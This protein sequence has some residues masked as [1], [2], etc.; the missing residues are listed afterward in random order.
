MANSI[1]LRFEDFTILEGVRGVVAGR[2]AFHPAVWAN[3]IHVTVA[4]SADC[5]QMTDLSP[6]TEFCDLVPSNYLP[7]MPSTEARLIQ[8]INETFFS[9]VQFT[10]FFSKLLSATI[11]VLPR[12]LVDTLQSFGQVLKIRSN[13]LKNQSFNGSTINLCESTPQTTLRPGISVQNLSTF[14]SDTNDGDAENTVPQIPGMPSYDDLLCREV[15]FVMLQLVIGLKKLQAKG[16]EELPL[17][18]S[19]VILCKDLENKDS[20][21]RLSILHG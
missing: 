9:S 3:Q 1:N 17:S 18:L 12:M 7:L 19:N 21:A 4:L 2:R 10:I 14:S 13:N 20:Q 8:G 11:S 6:V 5:N 15:G 16:I